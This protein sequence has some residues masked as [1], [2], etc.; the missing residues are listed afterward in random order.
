MRANN[1]GNNSS[2]GRVYGPNNYKQPYLPNIPDGGLPEGSLISVRLDL[3]KKTLTFGL[4]GKWNDK[5]AFIDIPSNS[6]Y[7][8][9]VL[10]K[11][12]TTIIGRSIVSK[13]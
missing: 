2:S 5:L 1:F 4:N 10:Q 6:W 12:C 7:P 9:V 8:C 11:A 13:M 3:D